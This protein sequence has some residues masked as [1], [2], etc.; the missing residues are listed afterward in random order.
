MAR[1]RYNRATDKTDTTPDIMV[2]IS[3]IGNVAAVAS[4]G[5]ASKTRLANLALCMCGPAD[6]RDVCLG[7]DVEGEPKTKCRIAL[8]LSWPPY[9]CDTAVR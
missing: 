4:D 9:R 5:K 2:M 7:A 3:T 6:V 8:S 1:L